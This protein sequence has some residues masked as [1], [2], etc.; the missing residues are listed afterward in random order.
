ME[1]PM[2]IGG[3]RV[4]TG[5]RRTVRLPYDGTPV[6]EVYVAGPGEV[7]AAVAAAGAA[8]PLMREMTLAERAE[9]L[10]R[11]YHRVQERREELALAVSSESGKPIREARVEV[12][13]AMQTLLFSADEA[14][15]LAG[16]VVPMEAAPTGKGHWAITVREPLGVIAAITPFNFPLNLSLHKIGP[17]L[18]AGN[19]VVHKPASATPV[20]ALLMAEIFHECGLPPG[21]LN[22]I[23]GPGG[24]IGDRLSTHPAVAMVTFT[25][26][27]DVGVRIRS[28]AGMKRVTLELGSNSALIV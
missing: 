18:A 1:Y 14:R 21:A 27:P 26:S 3:E 13:R 25:G 15:R 23:P 10:H 7:E 9:I 5:E 24:A 8:A 28:L 22:V 19:A 12:D 17:A 16:E 20:S 11:A 2:F 4:R 6:A